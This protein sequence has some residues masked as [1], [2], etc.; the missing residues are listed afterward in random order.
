MFATRIFTLAFAALLV[1][2]SIASA[3]INSGQ[4]RYLG[5]GMEPVPWQEGYYLPNIGTAD[6][7]SVEGGT[8]YNGYLGGEG[9]ITTAN[10]NSGKLYNGYG[11][12]YYEGYNGVGKITTLNL[13]GGTVYNGCI[14][15]YD[16]DNDLYYNGY[17]TITTANVKGGT[18]YNGY[19]GG[20][21]GIDSLLLSGGTV[22][23]TRW[24]VNLIYASGTYEGQTGYITTLTIAGDSTGVD[25]GNI[26]TLQFADDGSGILSIT[27][28]SANGIDIAFTNAIQANSVDLDYG[29]LFIDFAS[30]VNEG[31]E[32]TLF[33][34]FDTADVFGTLASLSIGDQQFYGVGT[35]RAFTYANG[36]WSTDVPEPA[37][38]AIIGLGLAGLGLARRRRK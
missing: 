20:A 30:M 23:N 36:V 32:F 27:A 15:Y 11:Y 7:I 37:T 26:G 19:E 3:Q 38:L 13:N 33:D 8:L 4:T 10:V 35:D 16:E 18:L 29:N 2:P 17:G 24:I 25:W 6:T 22:I 21:A 34:L 12:N 9:R 5:N 14:G 1:L 28:A 31:M